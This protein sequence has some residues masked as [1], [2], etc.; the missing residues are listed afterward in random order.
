MNGHTC[1]NTD[2]NLFT[3]RQYWYIERICVVKAAAA[4]LL[5]LLPSLL[6]I[7]GKIPTH[8]PRRYI[9]ESSSVYENQTSLIKAVLVSPRG[10][11]LPPFTHSLP[12]SSTSPR[13]PHKGKAASGVGR[14]STKL[15]KS[16]SYRLYSLTCLS[17]T[18]NEICK[19]YSR[20]SENPRRAMH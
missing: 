4:A 11:A 13:Q 1:G 10:G 20:V 18:R 5:L 17:V 7:Q 3:W 16:S 2:I 12:P 9:A 8:H 15:P 14:T 19:R 6:N